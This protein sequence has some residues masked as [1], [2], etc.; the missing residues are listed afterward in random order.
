VRLKI[1][2]DELE[3]TLQEKTSRLREMSAAISSLQG[4]D[5]EINIM[6]EDIANK[7]HAL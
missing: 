5:S 3:K 1:R 2:N 6:R 7:Q 4:R